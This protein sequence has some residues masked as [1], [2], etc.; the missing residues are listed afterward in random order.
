MQCFYINE[1]LISYARLQRTSVSTILNASKKEPLKEHSYLPEA[2]QI[3]YSQFYR[4]YLLQCKE[5]FMS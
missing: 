3:P 2:Q 4:H 5:E 1:S